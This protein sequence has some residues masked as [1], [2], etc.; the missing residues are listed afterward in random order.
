M[1]DRDT[2]ERFLLLLESDLLLFFVSERRQRVRLLAVRK[3]PRRRLAGR[4]PPRLLL[5][6]HEA[7]RAGQV[8]LRGT[9]LRG[10]VSAAY[11]YSIAFDEQM[12]IC[13]LRL[14]EGDRGYSLASIVVAI[15][16][17]FQ[18]SHLL[19]RPIRTG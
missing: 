13:F 7:D 6:H 1:D 17:F 2:A 19:L 8:L 3:V 4:L 15:L 18:L 11:L 10:V 12:L 16:L 9:P 14:A 5:Q